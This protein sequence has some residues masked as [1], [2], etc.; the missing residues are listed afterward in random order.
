[1]A[2]K[3]LKEVKPGIW[4]TISTRDEKSKPRPK[5]ESVCPGIISW[6]TTS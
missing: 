2:K 3:E 5:N 4:Q 6:L 1:M